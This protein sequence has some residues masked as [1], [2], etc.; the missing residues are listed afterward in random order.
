MA[1]TLITL[2]L[3]GHVL[4]PLR[5]ILGMKR[6]AGV[7]MEMKNPDAGIY[8]FRYPE[9][10]DADQVVLKTFEALLPVM[11]QPLF[12]EAAP[13][14]AK[15]ITPK[16]DDLNGLFPV[17]YHHKTGDAFVVVNYSDHEENIIVNMANIDYSEQSAVN[18]ILSGEVKTYHSAGVNVGID[19]TIV[20]LRLPAYG[21]GI[22]IFSK[23]AFSSAIEA[24]LNPSQ[25][26]S[27]KI[28]YLAASSVINRLAP[29]IIGLAALRFS[30]DAAAFEVK[31]ILVS[32]LIGLIVVVAII[33]PI[34]MAYFDKRLSRQ[35][36]KKASGI[37]EGITQPSKE[38]TVPARNYTP[39]M[40]TIVSLKEQNP[41]WNITENQERVDALF[42]L[43]GQ[44]FSVS[45]SKSHWHIIEQR[46]LSQ[47][48]HIHW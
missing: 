44:Q 34:V 5:Q 1:A 32:G 41:L 7:R 29:I 39:L 13:Q 10:Q 35:S 24:R 21:Y 48:L 20:N 17:V 23:T 28:H 14:S 36:V 47:E 40:E 30:S 46:S 18:E 42:E 31:T 33:L 3:P 38:I 2:I 6:P 11:T 26:V 8:E 22:I 27:S 16:G 12:R 9:L 25:M 37:P 15:L 45:A 19:G 43:N 4:I